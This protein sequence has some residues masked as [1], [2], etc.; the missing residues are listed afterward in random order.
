[1]QEYKNIIVTTD[2]SEP[3]LPAVHHG[4]SLARQLGSKIILAYVMEDRV[5]GW[6][7]ET[8]VGKIMERHRV[9]ANEALTRCVAE[10]LVGNEV[11]TVVVEGTPHTEIVKLA[12]ERKVDMIV[13]SMHGH[14]FLTHALAGSTAERVLHHA[15]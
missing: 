12:E 13:M 2:L 10:H 7:S 5:P 4:S 6:L 3:A 11:E 9:H 1:M 8:D 14:G 15:P